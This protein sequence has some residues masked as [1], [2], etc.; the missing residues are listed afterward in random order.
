V[1]NIWNV[2][3][4]SE[5]FVNIANKRRIVDQTRVTDLVTGYKLVNLILGQF[6]VE[7]AEAGAELH[8]GGQY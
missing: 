6:E 7:C 3:T 4:I 5:D 2:D 8:S 1:N